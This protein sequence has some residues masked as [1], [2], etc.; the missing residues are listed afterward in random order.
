MTR[1]VRV[2][3][4]MLAVLPVLLSVLLIGRGVPWGFLPA[5]LPAAG[6]QAFLTYRRLGRPRTG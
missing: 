6:A 4:A 5:L 3:V 1:R 2:A